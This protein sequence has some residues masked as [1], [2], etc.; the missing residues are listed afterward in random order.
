MSGC[1][2]T[3]GLRRDALACFEAAVDAVEPERLVREF[4]VNRSDLR[5]PSGLV[6]LAS[7]GK[8]A[9]A[10]A[11]GA[12]SVLGERL[13]GGVVIVPAGQGEDELAGLEVFAGGHPI[14]NREGVE[15]ARAIRS[16]ARQAGADDLFLVLISGGGSALMTSPTDDVSLEEIQA[17][18]DC[19]LRAGADIGELNI[20]RK[21]LDRL[22][23]GQLAQAA[24]PTPVVALVL[25]DVVGDPLDVIASGPVTADPTT[26][27]E[28]VAVIEEF[29]LWNETPE[30]VRR[31]LAAGV[32]GGVPETP[33]PGASCFRGVET[34]IVGNNRMAAEAARARAESLGYAA[35]VTSTVITGEARDVGRDLALSA[36]RLERNGDPM[37]PPAC[38]VSAGETTVTV[39]GPGRGG[40]NQEVALS[41]ALELE[42]AT[43]LL[44]GSFGTD[45]VDGPTDAAGAL[46]FG[47]SL[48]RAR[49]CGRDPSAALAD[50]DSY[51]FFA[52]LGDLIVTGPTG[53]NVMDIHLVLAGSLLR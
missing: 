3:E 51:R 41:A 18:T 26:F 32:E 28:A 38:L 30:A 19:L 16:L 10:M 47:D 52:E 9:A 53:T 48:A 49:G 22:K 46:A 2:P 50:N 25:S 14:P 31:H 36:L 15:G 20:V 6:W 34:A 35:V 7:V 12:L 33:K 1:S 29:E 23:G 5:Q 39:T 40:R 11:R 21:H 4:L 24:A 13:A 43:D 37:A 42:G 44:V 17:T 45:G 27:E 8:A